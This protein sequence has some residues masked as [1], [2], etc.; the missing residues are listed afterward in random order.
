MMYI[1]LV[2]LPII[3][4]CIWPLSYTVDLNHDETFIISDVNDEESDE[5]LKE[6][7]IKS[8]KLDKDDRKYSRLQRFVSNY[9]KEKKGYNS[10]QIRKPEEVNMDLV[11]PQPWEAGFFKSKS[12]QGEDLHLIRKK[13]NVVKKNSNQEDYDYESLKAEFKYNLLKDKQS[14]K[15]LKYIETKEEESFKDAVNVIVHQKKINCTAEDE[16]GIGASA[17]KCLVKGILSSDTTKKDQYRL[18]HRIKRVILIW[19]FIYIIIAV[20]LWCERGWGCCCCQCKFCRPRER[21]EK[22]KKYLMDNPVGT[23]TVN[24]K[25]IYYTPTNYEKYAYKNLEKKLMKL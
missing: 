25:K 22:A 18:L 7:E 15:T 6:D 5:M 23:Y 8:L 24:K 3:V 21:I 14:N 1:L 10:K 17:V 2:H 4:E 20:P 9:N 16:K 19:L 12:H 13:E 11:D